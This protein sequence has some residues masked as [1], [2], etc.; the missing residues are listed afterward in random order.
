MRLYQRI[1]GWTM[2][3]VLVMLFPSPVARADDAFAGAWQVHC[4][5]TTSTVS[6]G[7]DLFDDGFLFEN[8]QFSASAYACMGF[9]PAA[10]TI[11][12]TG[13]FTATLTSD[14]RGTVVWRGRA[15][16][17]SLYGSITWTKPDGSVFKYHYTGTPIVQ[18]TSSG[19]SGSSD[20]GS[21][22]SSSGDTGSSDTGST[23]TVTSGNG[24][25]DTGTS[26]SG[27]SGSNT[28]N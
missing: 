27:T 23:V 21:G 19:D 13:R 18:D 1:L 28:G 7:A 14:E 8:G 2:V 15:G 17:G 3:A 25:T 24:S 20:S 11:D 4:T 5:P 12:S 26:D 16:A 9:A 10:Y 6:L 22:S